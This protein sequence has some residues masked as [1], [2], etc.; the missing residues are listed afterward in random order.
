MGVGLWPE[1]DDSLIP[2]DVWDS[3]GVKA[4]RP[5][6]QYER[7]PIGFLTKELGIPERTIRWSINPHYDTHEWDGTPDPLVAMLEGLVNWE[8][9]GIESATGTGKSFTAAAGGV[10]WFLATWKSRV[11]TFAPKE[12]QLRLY[13]WA[14]IAKLWPAFQ[15]LFPTATLTDLRIRMDGSDN[16]GAWGYAVGVKADQQVAVNAAGMHA[17]HMLL[18]YEEMPGIPMP[19][20]AAGENTVTAPH[21]IRLGLGNPDNQLDTLHVFSTTPGVKHV[22]ISAFDHPNVVTGD[23]SIVPG[24]VSRASITKRR[25]LYGEGSPLYES[26]VR[27]ISPEQAVDSL[28]RLEWLKE[29]AKKYGNKEM[30]AGKRALGVDVANSENGDKSAIATW[31]GACLLD[32][33]AERCPNANLLGRQV[34]RKAQTENVEPWHIGVDPVGVGAGCANELAE[35]AQNSPDTEGTVQFLGGA[36]K[37]MTA[38][39]KAQDGTSMEWVVDANLFDNLR[40]QM[41]WQ[42][43]EDL[44][45]GRVAM[46]DDPDLFKELTTPRYTSDGGKVVVEPKKEIRKRLGGKS[47][48]RADAVIYGNWV[49]PRAVVTEVDPAPHHPDKHPGWKDGKPGHGRNRPDKW[50]PTA[51]DDGHWESPGYHMPSTTDYEE[52][53]P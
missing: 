38:S 4:V 30:R 17:E 53:V 36:M 5:L 48:D 45:K 18:I 25:N 32:V 11:F 7:D 13:I 34:W 40:S 19:V 31:Q 22:R 47:P 3:T 46:P 16:W 20:I 43:R 15:R 14:E 42:F 26:R 35:L 2:D 8:D 10:L 41:Y 12:D 44:R 24:A 21:N 33:K 28:I 51:K 50:K 29:A 49:R 37:P 1:T 9:V 27:G 6:S 52:F 39:A 23:A